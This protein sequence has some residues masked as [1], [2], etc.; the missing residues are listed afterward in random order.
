M[1]TATDIYSEFF[2]IKDATSYDT[3]SEQFD[4]FTRMLSL[5]FV[6]RMIH[7]AK[8]Q[9]LDRILD[10]GTGTGIVALNASRAVPKGGVTGVDLSEGM[11]AVAR[12]N[13]ARYA[14][15]GEL[16]FAR[17]DAEALRFGDQS[18]DVVLSLFAL[19][20]FPNP[21]KALTEMFR[22]L[23]P[24]GRIVLAVG[25]G[26]SLLS[27]ATVAEG[28]RHL[29]RL[30]LQRAGRLLVAPG[31]LD[32]LVN[33]HLPG[34]IHKEKSALAHAGSNLSNDMLALLRAAGFTRIQTMW[35]GREKYLDSPE[36]FWGIQST[37][38]SVARKRI[39]DGTQ[40]KVSA[41]REE[42][43]HICGQLQARHGRFVYP[44]GAFFVKAH[45]PVR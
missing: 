17:M 34:A 44:M 23:R 13:A 28:V 10:V 35:Y 37:F 14:L 40:D 9:P 21:S 2:K 29:H 12:Q 20:H 38:S 31:F 26:P 8:L 25:S 32:D 5:P 15:N 39:A 6:E 16:Q 27:L 18:F 22:V 45:R 3:V 7:I 4:A 1:L 41:L 11:L 36:D 24:G 33:K 30:I 42:F 19:L 43:F